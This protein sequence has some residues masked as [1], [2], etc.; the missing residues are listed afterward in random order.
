VSSIAL[1]LIGQGAR[2]VV[3]ELGAGRAANLLGTEPGRGQNLS[4][5][6]GAV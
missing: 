6:A 5:V 3:N 1:K 4:P 2:V